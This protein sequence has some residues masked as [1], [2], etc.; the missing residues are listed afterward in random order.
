M[1]RPTHGSGC[2]PQ[3]CDHCGPTLLFRCIVSHN[4]LFFCRVSSLSYWT[5]VKPQLILLLYW[6]RQFGIPVNS[7]L[8]S[9]VIGT[10][11]M[12]L[13]LPSVVFLVMESEMCVS[14]SSVVRTLILSHIPDRRSFIPLEI[15]IFGKKFDKLVLLHLKLL[16]TTRSLALYAVVGQ[17]SCGS[18]FQTHHPVRT[19]SLD[20][21]VS[22]LSVGSDTIK[23]GLKRDSV[24]HMLMCA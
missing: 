17:L 1:G 18:W 20:A 22:L 12:A 16:P 13:V 2:I 21:R 4:V 24:L 15:W 11:P 7:S 8:P 9:S 10:R 3:F 14:R 5:P 19:G 6:S 23:Q